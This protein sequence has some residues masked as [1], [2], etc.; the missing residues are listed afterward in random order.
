MAPKIPDNIGIYYGDCRPDRKC[1][2]REP[3]TD[4]A[5][6]DEVIE[7]LKETIDRI[8]KW[9]SMEIGGLMITLVKLRS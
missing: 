7:L 9:V 5:T 4:K 6:R 3:V 1:V 2:A 8:D